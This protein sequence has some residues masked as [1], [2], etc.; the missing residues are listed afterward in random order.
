[1]LTKFAKVGVPLIV[2]ENGIATT[3]EALRSSFVRDHLAV[4]CETIRRGVDVIGYFHWS[5]MDNFEWALGTGPR[6]GLAAVDYATQQR[7]PRPA[8]ELYARVCRSNAL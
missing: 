1:M 7:T 4:L 5:L 2:T 8:A 3:D 6:F